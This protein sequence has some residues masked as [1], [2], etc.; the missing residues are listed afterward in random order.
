MIIGSGWRRVNERGVAPR[1]RRPPRNAPRRELSAGKRACYHFGVSLASLRRPLLLSV[2]FGVLVS[3][4]LAFYADL[5]ATRDALSGFQWRFLPAVLGLTLLNYLLRWLKWQL[6]LRILGVAGLSPG[7][8]ALIFFAGLAMV[9][10]PAKLGEWLKSLLLREF[11][12][13]PLPRSAP[14][15]FAERLTDGLAMLGLA[16]AGAATYQL[17]VPALAGILLVGLA[18]V[19]AAQWRGLAL[20]VL[21]RIGRL[22]RLGPPARALAA[23]YESAHALLRPSALLPAVALGLVSWGG[24]CLAFYL[25]LVGLGVEERLGLLLQATFILATATLL[26]SA[27]LLPGGLGAAEGSIAGLLQ[28]LVGLPSATAVAATLLIRAGTLWFGVLVGLGALAALSYRL[29]P[30]RAAE[31]HAEV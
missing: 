28:L 21:D 9:L 18:A 29:A 24:E 8:S 23:M 27:S 1:R 25:V 3:T 31:R 26:G 17:G 13:V 15:V 14:I 30:G 2:L 11:A 10:T 4:G 22:P 5:P 7:Q 20:G 12:G 6:Y 16:A 19:L